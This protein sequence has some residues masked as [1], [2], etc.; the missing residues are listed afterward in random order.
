MRAD[1]QAVTRLLRT[2]RGQIDGVLKMIEEDRYCIDVLN[3]MLAAEAVLRR[4]E[5]EVLRA[6]MEGCGAE[7]F[8]NGGEEERS[9]KIDEIIMAVEKMERR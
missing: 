6:H 8:E 1:K 7:A 9:R 3:Q 5:R 2:A 4:A